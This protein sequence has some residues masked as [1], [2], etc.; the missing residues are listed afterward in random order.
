MS[1]PHRIATAA[2]VALAALQILWYGWWSPPASIGR[3]AAISFALR[4][5]RIS[6]IWVMRNPDKLTTWNSTR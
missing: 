1:V 5:T 2:L 3:L 6:D 4:G